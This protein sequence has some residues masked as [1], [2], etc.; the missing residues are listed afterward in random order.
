M[1]MRRAILIVLLLLVVLI[2]AVFAF[3]NPERI[4][5]D[6]GIVRLENVPVPLA[7]AVTLAVGWVLGLLSAGA[8]VLRVSA[9]RQ[10]LRRE[11][12]SAESE[13][14]SLRSLPLHDAD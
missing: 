3:N 7:L 5:L 1:G 13:V 8:A 2:A 4:P 10:R 12:R 6:L 14:K 11:L 9:E